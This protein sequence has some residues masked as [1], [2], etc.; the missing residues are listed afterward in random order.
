MLRKTL[1]GPRLV[2]ILMCL[3][4]VPLLLLPGE[5]WTLKT[6]E[7]WLPV[8]LTAL[9]VVAL[10]QLLIRRTRSPAPWYILS[11]AQGFSIISRLMMLLPHSTVTEKGVQRFDFPYVLLAVI[12]MALSTFEIW[13]C[14]LP[15]VR[16]RVSA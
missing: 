9:V 16:S 14:D 7:W 5:S 6:Q 11:F 1:S 4:V 10:V 13:Y 8:L 2:T 3:Q 12:S 15:E